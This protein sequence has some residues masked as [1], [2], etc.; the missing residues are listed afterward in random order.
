MDVI[1][2][3]GCFLFFHE[4]HQEMIR[5]LAEHASLSQTCLSLSTNTDKYICDKK[6]LSVDHALF[7]EENHEIR[8]SRIE[9]FLDTLGADARFPRSSVRVA[10]DLLGVL[11]EDVGTDLVVWGLGQEYLTKTFKE[12]HEADVVVFMDNGPFRSSNY[13]AKETSHGNPTA[14]RES[15]N[16]DL[17]TEG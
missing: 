14:C 12:S 6:G 13:L 1:A 11:R 10:D 7:I 8:S 2:S 15:S 4:S 17:F 16:L 9:S 5:K 3:S